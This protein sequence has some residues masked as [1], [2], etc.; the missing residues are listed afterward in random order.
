MPEDSS[1]GYFHCTV[2]LSIGAFA[3]FLHSFQVKEGERSYH[4][5]LY[6]SAVSMATHFCPSQH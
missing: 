1:D 4:T 5:S 2:P 6:S 3:K